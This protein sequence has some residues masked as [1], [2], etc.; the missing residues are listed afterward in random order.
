MDAGGSHACWQFCLMSQVHWLTAHHRSEPPVLT[1]DANQSQ[2]TITLEWAAEQNAEYYIVE[3][4]MGGD[5]REIG[6]T[7]DTS[8]TYNYADKGLEYE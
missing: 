8:A 3:G 7:S 6:S 1:V 4:Y 5:W 2:T